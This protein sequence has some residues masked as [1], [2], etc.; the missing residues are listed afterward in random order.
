M[1]KPSFRLFFLF[2]K[3]K[4]FSNKVA[5][6]EQ[7][8]LEFKAFALTGRLFKIRLKSDAFIP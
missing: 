3:D 2:G 6:K 1:R 5:L 4:I 8:L 7:K